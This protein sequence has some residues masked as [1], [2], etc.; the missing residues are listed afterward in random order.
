MP[1]SAE[2]RR[3]SRPKSSPS[4]RPSRKAGAKPAPHDGSAEARLQGF[5][6][7]FDDRVAKLI[8]SAR[9]KLRA[10]FPAANELVYDN[11]NFLVIGYSPTERPSDTIAALTAN[12]QGIGLAFPYVGASLPDP[13]GLLQGAGSSNRFIRLPS[14]DV[15]DD[16]GVR[17]VIDAAEKIA[18]QPLA[19]KGKLII[20]SVSAKQRPRR[21]KAAPSA[22]KAGRGA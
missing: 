18:K 15:L 16:S 13:S 22:K 11:Y 9:K 7:K 19:A 8:R 20:R 10:R 17:S 1:S 12:A 4:A 21:E 2:S 14:A 3:K 5:I 6:D